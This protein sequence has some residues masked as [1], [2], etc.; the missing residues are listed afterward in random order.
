MAADSSDDLM[1]SQKCRRSGA[2]MIVGNSSAG[3]RRKCAVCPIAGRAETGTSVE[4]RGGI[5]G[6]LGGLKDLPPEDKARIGQLIKVLA[7]ERQDKDTYRQQLSLQASRLKDLEEER[8]TSRK[9]ERAMLERV[10]KS[11]KLLREYQKELVAAKSSKVTDGRREAS[12]SP[13][14]RVPALPTPGLGH[15]PRP[16]PAQAAPPHA[17]PAATVRG[18]TVGSDTGGC[19]AMAAAADAVAA[20]QAA[21]LPEPTAVV[22]PSLQPRQPAPASHR[23]L[24]ARL[25]S[26][27][28]QAHAPPILVQEESRSS[29]RLRIASPRRE[30]DP[31]LRGPSPTLRL[32]HDPRDSAD[33]GGLVSRRPRRLSPPPS[34]LSSSDW[35][36][37]TSAGP[38]RDRTERSAGRSSRERRSQSAEE[39]RSSF[40]GGCARTVQQPQR[41][42]QQQV[43]DTEHEGHPQY[44]S[45]GV[46]RPSQVSLLQRYLRIQSGNDVTPS[47]LQ[48]LEGRSNRLDKHAVQQLP[49][50][51]LQRDALSASPVRRSRSKSPSGVAL[52]PKPSSAFFKDGRQRPAEMTAGA[53]APGIMMVTPSP[54]PASPVIP[55]RPQQRPPEA[56]NAPKPSFLPRSI[57]A[58]RHSRASLEHAIGQEAADLD[59]GIRC[60]ETHTYHAGQ[61]VR[62][63]AV[64]EEVSPRMPRRYQ[65]TAAEETRPPSLDRTRRGCS[66]SVSDAGNSGS[67]R[68]IGSVER[69]SPG[70][71]KSAVPGRHI[72]VPSPA[73]SSA[74]HSRQACTSTAPVI[75]N[76]AESLQPLMQ[77]PSLPTRALPTQQ[78]PVQ[79]CSGRVSGIE[80]KP[81]QMSTVGGSTGVGWAGM[82]HDGYYAPSMFDVL[83]SVESALTS[84]KDGASGGSP[85]GPKLAGCGRGGG[86]DTGSHGGGIAP[87]VPD[88]GGV[89]R[90]SGASSGSRRNARVASSAPDMDME[91]QM[92]PSASLGSLTATS[93]T[94][95]FGT[96][97]VRQR[98]GPELARLQSELT[99]LEHEVYG[100]HITGHGASQPGHLARRVAGQGSF[101]AV[102]HPLRGGGRGASVADV[103]PSSPPRRSREFD[104]VGGVRASWA[105][106]ARADVSL[107]MS[108]ASTLTHQDRPAPMQEIEDVM[109]LLQRS[110]STQSSRSRSTAAHGRDSDARRG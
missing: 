41:W 35:R 75:L 81:G 78:S 29:S 26:Y 1:A 36:M 73:A 6:G 8:H 34:P 18:S 69:T 90:A 100:G 74:E 10:S 104:L 85:G 39:L 42:R 65:N 46:L 110:D 62:I 72:R 47:A 107:P 61:T 83:D 82:I 99:R 33:A 7:Q 70:H 88:I 3:R 9:Q 44:T 49:T 66:S 22:A 93:S 51:P 80:G 84:C 86:L 55:A 102:Q 40:D 87:S 77:S 68:L 97:D 67:H 32:N 11:L 20:A 25:P 96:G 95:V 43:R 13:H 48:L 53:T 106:K 71:E 4:G 14:A 92:Q 27:P 101:A 23:P 63:Q 24:P 52:R 105:S 79:R 19:C 15:S 109:A 64:P 98:C 16:T 94:S 54:R 60:N 21:R 28:P 91:S 38:C 103:A 57:L 12:V 5:G 50:T 30:P 108:H 17:S 2:G 37:S 45:L 56:A 59:G 76:S 31:T 89:C 58:Q